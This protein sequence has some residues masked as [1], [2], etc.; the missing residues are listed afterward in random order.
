MLNTDPMTIQRISAGLC[1]L[2]IATTM[3]GQSP[4]AGRVGATYEIRR[5]MSK[6]SILREY[7]VRN[8]GPTVQGGRIVDLDVNHSNPREFYVAYASGGVF[9]TVNNGISFTPI[10]DNVDV[11]GVGDIALSQ[12]NPRVLYVGT[13]EKNSSRSSYAGSGIY[14][15]TDGGQTW[16]HLGLPETQHISRIVIH[17]ENDDIV[18]V[19]SIGALYSKNADR[20][21]FKSTDGGQTWERTLFINDSTGVIDL[22]INPK[23]PNELWA[24]SWERQRSAWHFKGN[25]PGSAIYRSVDGG[26]NWTK[27]M[28]GMPQGQQVGRIGLDISPSQPNILY[29]VLDNQGEIEEKREE[30]TKKAGLKLDDFRRFT[31]ERVLGLDDKALNEFLRDSGFPRKYDAHRVKD[32]IRQGKYDPSAIANYFGDDADTNLTN[33]KIIGAE[34]YRSDDSGITWKKM[35]SYDLDNVFYSYGY[36][37]GEIRVAPD[38]PDLIYLLG[39]PLLKSVDAGVTWHR[40]DTLRGV[41]NIHVDHQA[42]WINPND[43]RHILLGNDGGLYQS[44]DEGAEWLH[45]NNMPVGQFYTVN[46]DMERPYNVYGGLQDNGVLKGSSR[47]VPNQ[48]RHWE[49][50]LGGDGM[51]VAPDPRNS[52]LVYTGFQ[53][54]N[55]YRIDLAEGRRTR[56]TPQHDIGEQP[57]RWNWRSPLILSSH[58]PDIVYMGANRLY[59]SLDRGEHWEAISGDLT[60]SLPQ[61]NVPFSTITTVAESPLRFGLLYVGTDDGNVWV[62]QDGGTTWTLI[63]EGLPEGKWVSSIFASPHREGTVFIS[64]NGY[65]EDDFRT[66]LFMSDDYG[67]TWRSIKGNLPESVANV[68]IQDPV[69]SKLLYCGLDAGTFVSFDSGTTWH[70]LN[71]ML[72]VPAYDMLVHPR[73]H[74]LV[75]ATH[76]RSVFVADVKPLQQLANATIEKPVL[77]FA[78][79]RIRHSERWG[80]QN[81]GWAKPFTPQVDVLYFVGK[82]SAAID[83]EIYDEKQN[84]VRRMTTDAGKGFHTFR[85]DVKIE[86]EQHAPKKRRSTVDQAVPLK[87]APKGKYKIKLINGTDSSQVDLEIG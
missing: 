50:I 1:S 56:I 45:I 29:A 65:R 49:E 34:V 74:E 76:G 80:Q 33:T 81:V 79:E 32:D 43:S 86:D 73:D 72:N 44:Y 57:L 51:F 84:R 21:V 75:V 63:K 24:A 26:E 41:R 36:Y 54:G 2:L 12:S 25:G 59:R 6:N 69:N 13:G 62:N 77:A 64:L 70:L 66:W 14:K 19:A 27:A 10:F 40:L 53:F 8:I 11:L 16:T 37:F 48:T 18:W 7:Q 42:F 28:D 3:F 20:G 83:I 31:R 22:I 67:K 58:N 35:N 46:V 38:N 87:Y 47:S 39:V 71:G 4:D 82:P 68:V 52:N 5:E 55:Y 60:R 23:N 9:K 30:D 61:G 85:W 15:S 17:P 78:P